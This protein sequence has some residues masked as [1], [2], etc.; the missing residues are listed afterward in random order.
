MWRSCFGFFM[1][2]HNRVEIERTSQAHFSW[3]AQGY[4]VSTRCVRF[5][6][7]SSGSSC[8]FFILKITAGL[9]VW[10]CMRINDKNAQT[11]RIYW[12]H[13]DLATKSVCLVK[14]SCHG[15]LC[16]STWFEP[17]CKASCARA[18]FVWQWYVRGCVN[19]FRLKFFY[20]R[21]TTERTKCSSCYFK[22]FFFFYFS[23]VSFPS[24]CWTVGH[25]IRS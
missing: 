11:M 10:S 20:L 8:F 17:K 4:F 23:I 12:R 15:E 5:F 1:W 2:F 16:V 6:F 9:D 24:V 13:S 3:R 21:R 22:C 19:K 14:C 7:S 18:Q 25:I